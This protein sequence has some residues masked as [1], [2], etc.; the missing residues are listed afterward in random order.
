MMPRNRALTLSAVACFA[1]ACFAVAAA[2]AGE[3][4]SGF[5]TPPDSAKPQT[6]WHWADGNIGRE[7]ITAELEAMRRVGLGGVHM[8]TVGHYPP[9]PNPK[10]PCLS[11]EWYGMVRHALAE[12]E[13]LGLSFTAQDC[14]GWTTAGGPWIT[15]D[16]A[17][18]HVVCERQSVTNG[19]LVKLAAPPSW[20]EKGDSYYRDI[21]V[22]AFPTP[23]ALLSA[24]ALP[25]PKATSNFDGC[26][27]LGGL[28][29]SEATAKKADG[30]V[31]ELASNRTGWVQFEFPGPVLCRSVRLTGGK[32]CVEPE[33]Q[34]PEVWASEDGQ[35]FRRVAGL[36]TCV[37]VY[38][39]A[40][41]GV[42]H[43]IPATRARFFRLAWEGPVR[44]SLRR[45]AW[46]SEPE[47]TAH[48]AQAGEEGRTMVAEP[49]MAEEEGTAVAPEQ[50]LDITSQLDRQGGLAWRAPAG[51]WTVLR[52][53]YRG[54]GKR[55]APAPREASGLECDKFCRETVAFHF[56]Q[57]LGKILDEAKAA[58]SRAMKGLLVDS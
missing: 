58:K 24:A 12:C 55:N 38:N 46:S 42:T 25:E 29:G 19:G 22:L 16:K 1:V 11:P 13:R 51:A 41:D 47:L 30:V 14:A 56:D 52:V 35:S 44:L 6:W 53:G 33:E 23:A 18:F 40:E 26:P 4:E 43:A 28:G 21:A 27:E 31:C 3:L 5:A 57:Y 2:F 37:S 15:P 49:D 36:S 54:T 17:M 48:K 8:F 39:C 45:V 10:V 9:I 7:G 20:P 50:M 34:R 32:A